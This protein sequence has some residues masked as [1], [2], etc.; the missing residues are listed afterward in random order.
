MIR[1]LRWGKKNVL[2]GLRYLRDLWVR[3]LDGLL[4]LM[5]GY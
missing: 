2:L 3:V 4:V 5:L 1:K